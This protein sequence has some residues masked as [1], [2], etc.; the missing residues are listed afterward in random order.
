MA[1]RSNKT[2]CL[3]NCDGTYNLDVVKAFLMEMNEKHGF[4]FAIGKHNFGLQQMT[5]F[6]EN[7][8]PQIHMDYAVFALHAHESRLS[9]NEDNAGIGYAKVYRALL[10]A[11]KNKVLIVIGGDNKYRND[12]E[13]ERAVISRWA[14]GKVASQFAEE[15]LDGRISFI[16]SWNK[17]HREIHEEA[18]LHFFDPSKHGTKFE[19][20][21]RQKP[22]NDREESRGNTKVIPLKKGTTEKEKSTSETEVEDKRRGNGERERTWE[23][24]TNKLR[25][26]Q[27]RHK[28][29]AVSPYYPAGTVQ[30]RGE[31]KPSETHVSDLRAKQFTEPSSVRFSATGNGGISNTVLPT[32]WWRRCID[33]FRMCCSCGC[34]HD[35]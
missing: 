7:T 32:T 1:D 8:I 28:Y 18:L 24:E 17:G 12:D 3:F 23:K 19:H 27:E 9:I 26:P 29:G 25:G 33:F 22:T 20:Q 15:Y 16:F 21:P 4:N 35:D 6:C 34:I 10:E 5:D 11:T 13:E 14:R 2:I 30:R 31:W